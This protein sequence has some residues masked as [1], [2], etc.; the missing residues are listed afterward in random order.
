MRQRAFTLIELLIAIG[1]IVLLM[2]MA[3]P[4]YAMTKRQAERINTQALLRKVEI[5]LRLFKTDVRVYPW[6]CYLQPGN[7]L[8]NPAFNVSYPDVRPST[9]A[10]ANRLA[11]HLATPFDAGHAA[12]IRADADAARAV[13]AYDLRKLKGDGTPEIAND[14]SGVNVLLQENPSAGNLG[15]GVTTPGYSLFVFRLSDALPYSFSGSTPNIDTTLGLPAYLNRIAQERYSLAMYAGAVRITGPQMRTVTGPTGTV[16]ASANP[17]AGTR[18][19]TR[20]VSSPASGDAPGWSDNYLAGEIQP[21][22]IDGGQ[23]LDLWRR[24]LAYV[25]QVLPGCRPAQAQ[26]YGTDR[27]LRYVDPLDYGLG[28]VG[29]RSLAPFDSYTQKPLLADAATDADTGQE[30]LPDPARPEASDIRRYAA[31]GLVME[32]ELWSAGPDGRF[33]WR[34]DD[35]VNRDNLAPRDYLIGV[36]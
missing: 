36:R 29:R 11:F 27:V 19:T 16:Y 10:W 4:V 8:S 25:C 7:P 5:A 31:E 14:S 26:L 30:F 2:G 13:F 33:A 20:V 32:F 6:D 9:P 17:Q 22:Q 34:R 24:P 15:G 21:T 3:M 28:A 35:A 1:I 12:D 23:I 18:A